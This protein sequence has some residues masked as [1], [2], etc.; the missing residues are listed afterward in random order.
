M[1]LTSLELNPEQTIAVQHVEGPMLVI[2]GAGSGKTR[3]I[4]ARIQY[5]LSLGV[6]ASEILAVTFTNKAAE[7]MGERIHKLT[8]TLV[9]TST[10]HSL[11]AKIL[12]QAIELLGY[13]SHF[14]I[15]DEDDSEKLL[16][17]C[18]RELNI[19]E[20]KGS[21]KTARLEIS[22]AKNN[23][24]EL[25]AHAEIYQLYQRKLKEC[26]AVDFDDLLFLPV[27][28]FRE[29][30]EILAHYQSQWRFIL[31]DEYQDTN[32]T[33]YA[34]IRLLAAKHNNVFAVGDP[35]QSIYSWRG[36]TIENIL[37]FEK[38]FPGAKIVPLEQNYRST[39]I[40][41]QA[42]NALISHNSAR[43]PKIYGA[44]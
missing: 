31:I 35:D 3:I 21:L 41:L 11:G 33:Q 30:P 14:T 18:F 42:S 19:K 34:L 32:S 39:N 29:F 2:A 22:Q 6:P 28:L 16:K 36:A 25:K 4:T 9:L 38:D 23:L 27:R 13:T 5:L 44:L 37:N 7:E 15:F 17:E 26:N 10:F 8:E 12:R 24:V 1:A 20:D 40:I 43:T